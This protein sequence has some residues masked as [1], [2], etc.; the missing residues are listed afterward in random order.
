[1]S[2]SFPESLINITL[3]LLSQVFSDLKGSIS[4]SKTKKRRRAITDAMTQMK[5][6]IKPFAT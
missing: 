5:F 6:Q 2:Q 3:F 4:F 1:M